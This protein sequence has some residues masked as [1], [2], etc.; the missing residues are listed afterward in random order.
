MPLIDDA[1]AALTD[2]RIALGGGDRIG[3]HVFIFSPR[4]RDRRDEWYK[5]AM[6]GAVADRL[7]AAARDAL[8]KLEGRA[9]D[10]QA[11]A[12]FDFDAMVNGSI[13]VMSLAEVPAIADW[14]ATIA[15]DDWPVRFDGDE[16]VVEKARFYVTKLNFADG[17]PL[18]IVR[19]SRGLTVSLQEKGAVAAA[20]NRERNEMIAIDGAVVSFDGT[21]DFLA[22]EGMVFISN[23]RTFESVTNIRDVTIRK[24]AE[25][26][27]A[28]AARFGLG[29]NAESLKAEIGKRT[30]L[31]ERLAAAHRYGIIAN[32]NP[33]NLVDR[34]RPIVTAGFG[35]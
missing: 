18:T 7:A 33:Q 10:D 19:G 25:A 4:T 26:L 31:A 2:I 8:L 28:L 16:R 21:I 24:S 32:I 13:G 29:G 35:P 12:E 17:R 3:C 9:T 6:E 5:I 20:F 23:F 22:W 15:G 14:L 30:L 27:D 34:N 1:F 11:L